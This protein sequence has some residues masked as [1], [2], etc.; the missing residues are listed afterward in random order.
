MTA[1]S[2]KSERATSKASPKHISSVES[3][4]GHTHSSSPDIQKMH[5]CGPGAVHASRSPRQDENAVST[6]SATSGPSGSN[7]SENLVLSLC[8]ASK[9]VARLDLSGLT[10]FSM[11]WKTRRTPAGRS[12]S[13]LRASVRRT[14]DNAC[15]GWPSPVTNDAK[16]SEYTYA[17]GDHSR[18]SLKLGGAARLA[19]WPTPTGRDTRGA[20][21]P[22]EI[23][24]LRPTGHAPSVLVETAQLASWAT[25][26]RRDYR[27]ANAK[28]WKERGGGSRGEQ[29]NNQA[30]HLVA[31]GETQ[32]GSNAPTAKSGQLN[33]AFS[34]WLQGFPKEWDEASPNYAEWQ[35]AIES[36]D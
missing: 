23:N 11:T 27:F 5:P 22:E 30:V 6:T 18:P 15:T 14:S 4:V 26:A 21:S 10:L 36:D 25:P 9:L 31:S 1:A 12:I 29:L 3:A 33:A 7:S 8:L 19:S 24:A 13:A 32:S 20:R 17:N 28:P 34:R 35:A 2:P 16:D